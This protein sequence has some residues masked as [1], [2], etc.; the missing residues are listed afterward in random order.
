M[1]KI[2]VISINFYIILIFMLIG[3]CSKY[4]TY[5]SL[6]MTIIFDIVI[7]TKITKKPNVSVCKG[8]IGLLLYQN[9]CIGLGAHLFSNYDQSLRIITQFPFISIAIVWF[10]I[11]L[12]DIKNGNKNKTRRYFYVLLFFVFFSMIFGHGTM[13]AILMNIRNLSVFFMT[14]EIGRYCIKSKEDVSKLIKYILNNAFIFL[15]FGII[16]N[17]AGYSGYK[18]IGIDEVYFAKGIEIFGRLDDRFYTTLISR[19]VLRMGSI[20]YEPVNLAYF[21]S[22]C[23]IVSFFSSKEII[24]K[25]K[26]I[27]FIISVIGLILTFGKGGYLITIAAF[28][29]YYIQTFLQML[30]KNKRYKFNYKITICLLLLFII[31]FCIYYYV[32]I[33]AASNVHFWAIARTWK[34]VLAKPYGYGIGTGGNMSQ[35]LNTGTQ[36]IILDAGGETAFM[37]F[38]YQIGVQGVLFLVLCLFSMR[39]MKIDIKNKL[40]VVFNY[41][42]IIIIVISFLQDNTFTPQCISSFMFILGSMYN[43]KDNKVD[44]KG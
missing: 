1:K 9:L 5:I 16:L 21:Y 2:S 24:G 20:L 44:E 34:N 17:I 7:G 14:Y 22:F 42:P 30:T 6:I 18:F 29:A 41:I 37:A 4:C 12:R 15:I 8:I 40:Y 26:G 25:L 35:L 10:F 31:S 32:N 23:T 3:A 38:L 28:A 19:Q 36:S 13:N 43:I 33:G 39:N 11:E 27:Y